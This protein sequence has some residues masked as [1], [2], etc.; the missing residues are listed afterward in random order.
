MALIMAAAQVNRCWYFPACGTVVEPL[1]WSRARYWPPHPSCRSDAVTGVRVS[2]VF[3]RISKQEW[4]DWTGPLTLSHRRSSPVLS[5]HLDEVKMGHPRNRREMVPEGGVEPPWTKVHWILSPARLPIPPL[6]PLRIT[7]S[8]S[9]SAEE[10]QPRGPTA[11]PER[12]ATSTRSWHT[13]SNKA[14]TE[15]TARTGRGTLPFNS[16][17][18]MARW[19]KAK[20]FK[21]VARP[22]PTVGMGLQAHPRI[23]EGSTCGEPCR[24]EEVG[25]PTKDPSL[26]ENSKALRG[27]QPG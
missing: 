7:H 22:L 2:I 4:L 25:N 14:L 1:L 23:A 10:S 20:G 13:A 16:S 18:G 24:L 19:R 9:A 5:T 26:H 27:C 15:R 6:R 3:S 12:S 8:C 17:A 11:S 21:P